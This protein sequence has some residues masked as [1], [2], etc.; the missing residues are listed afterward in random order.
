M[1]T[2]QRDLGL[3]MITILTDGEISKT[4]IQAFKMDYAPQDVISDPSDPSDPI[5]PTTK[6]QKEAKRNDVKTEI[7]VNDEMA[8]RGE[9]RGELATLLSGRCALLFRKRGEER[10]VRNER[11]RTNDRQQQQKQQQQQ[12]Q[13]QQQRQQESAAWPLLRK[14]R[15]G[16]VSSPG[17]F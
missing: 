15:K 5:P 10:E 3:D 13:W 16:L 6:C 14:R 2:P 17:H 11:Y 9:R 12:Q 7:K 4:V 8:L 1:S